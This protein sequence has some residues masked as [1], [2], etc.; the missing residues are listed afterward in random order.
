MVTTREQARAELRKQHVTFTRVIASDSERSQEAL[1]R[2]IGDV[3]FISQ[4]D[5]SELRRAFGISDQIQNAMRTELRT[6]YSA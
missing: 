2:Q 1:L 5:R 6:A 3:K 4:G